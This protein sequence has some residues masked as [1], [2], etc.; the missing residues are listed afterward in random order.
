MTLFETSAK[1]GDNVEAAFAHLA[2]IVA[3]ARY[4]SAPAVPPAANGVQ[5]K[6]SKGP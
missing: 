6:P 2:G 1:A 4:G 3:D 5:L